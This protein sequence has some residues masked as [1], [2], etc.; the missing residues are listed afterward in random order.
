M[1]EESGL[2]CQHD[3]RR[4]KILADAYYNGID[5]IEVSSASLNAQRFLH[6]NFLKADHLDDL[7]GRP[8]LIEVKG[9]VRITGLKVISASRQGDHIVVEV[10]QAGDFSPYTLSIDA[11]WMDPR[12][13]RV[14]F[15]FK[16]GCP[17]DFDCREGQVCPPEQSS[18]PAIDYMAKDYASFRQALVDLIPVLAPQWK[19]RNPSDLG[20]ALVELLAYAGDNLSYYQ[21][22][23][24]NEAYLE[25]ARQRISVRRHSR[26]IN[27]GMHDGASARAFVQID[28]ATPGVIPAGTP[29]LSRISIP[30]GKT[31]PG[32]V[33]SYS[34][35]ALARDA[36]DA[37]FETVK[38]AYIHPDLSEISMYA[39]GDRSCC[40][41]RGTTRLE[42]EGN[43]TSQFSTGHLSDSA[44]LAGK[45]RDHTD[46]VAAYIHGRMDPGTQTLLAGY[47][48]GNPVSDNLST[49]LIGELNRL[50]ADRSF[51]TQ[52]RFQGISLGD[53]ITQLAEEN[54]RGD[55]LARLN[56]F[57]L[58]AAFPDEVSAS[59]KLG[60]GD[61]LLFE[62]ILGAQTGLAADADPNHRQIVRLTTA[63][64][65]RDPLYENEITRVAWSARDALKFSL[66]LTA[67]TPAGSRTISVARGNQILADHGKRVEKEKHILAKFTLAE[68]QRLACR[69][70]LEKGPLSFRVPLPD[71]TGRLSPAAE[72][73]EADPHQALSQVL[74]MTVDADGSAS[75]DWQPVPHLLESDSSAHD[76]AVETDND[77]RALIRFGDG[78]YGEAPPDEAAVT[79]DY[80]V[81]VGRSG[82]VGAHTFAHVISPY[83]S[84]E[85]PDVTGV[86]NPLPAW[87]GIEPEP[88]AE[89][90]QK[91]PAAFQTDT[92]RAVTEDDYTRLA[93][94]HPELQSAVAAFRWTGS[95]HTVFITIDPLDRTGVDADL[96]ERVRRWMIRYTQ[97]GYDLEIDPPVYVPL[98][99]ELDVCVDPSHFRGDVKEALLYALDNRL[100]ASGE[101]G[102]FYSNNFT[103]GQAL[104]LSRLYA[105][106]EAVEGVD[107]AEV[108]VFQRFGK[109]PNR[110]IAQGYL[111]MGRLEIA[112]VDNDPSFPEN[113]ILRLN[114]AGGK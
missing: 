46:K 71:D 67:E 32:V 36:A 1:P 86:R 89:V 58:E 34:D 75:D 9:G 23:I 12:F 92:L 99:I 16:A 66:C 27:Y 51:Y 111:P 94:M 72:L 73:W 85:W 24:A 62:E 33:I 105:A 88:I 8:D 77:G 11:D 104:Y 82:N 106:V 79:V 40:L 45:L 13:N 74:N 60:A 69:F 50:L 70:S 108:K 57:L 20:I 87:G 55:D 48:D 49:A 101:S 30:V 7:N 29:V 100:H 97:T 109:L 38:A 65:G 44:S 35:R 61:Y 53:H 10:D 6:V 84:V 17:S 54:P 78:T 83:A 93:S 90:R 113:G 42:L 31:A 96:E 39:W 59:P 28:S 47:A 37:A 14:S 25:T 5:Y 56:R 43:L 114:L 21:D 2:Y 64:C 110:E 95:W 15:S 80:R 19:E 4:E 98:E 76:F 91:A 3:A 102:F 63:E 112:R 81:G 107:S 52:T 103:F 68:S 18:A 22:S 41:P 26:L